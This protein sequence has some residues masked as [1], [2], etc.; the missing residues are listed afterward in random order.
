MACFNILF[1]LKRYVADIEMKNYKLDNN[2]LLF[3][4]IKKS[5]DR[6]FTVK[7]RLEKDNKLLLNIKNNCYLIILIKISPEWCK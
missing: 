7:Y 3:N 4:K 5:E 6:I 1:K 2:K